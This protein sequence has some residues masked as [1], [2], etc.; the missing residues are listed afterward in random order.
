MLMQPSMNTVKKAQKSAK[1][2]Q[3]DIDVDKVKAPEKDN[4][5]SNL[6]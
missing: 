1:S 6:A 4:P 3:S 2:E 5:L